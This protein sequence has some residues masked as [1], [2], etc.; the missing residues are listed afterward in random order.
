[1]ASLWTRAPGLPVLVVGDQEAEAH[2]GGRPGVRCATLEVDPY[3]RTRA[4]R[5][6][7]LAGRV[8]PLL[9]GLSPWD[10]TLYVDA[11]SAFRAD[12]A[13]GF[14][15]LERWDFALAETE[16]RTLQD[17]IAGAE[18]TLW[19]AQWTG[20]PHLLYHN[21]GMLF[22]RKH[23]RVQRLFQLWAEEWAR[24]EGWDEQVALLRALL[25]S[26]AL[27]LTLPYTWNHRFGGK[28]VLLH[29]R[30]GVGAARQ[31]GEPG[32]EAAEGEAGDPEDPDRLVRVQVGPRRYVR[33]RAH[34]AEMYRERYRKE[35]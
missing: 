25:R 18:E 17:S 2:F 12:P 15:L 5:V 9:Y 28:A 35:A 31:V 13:L 6:Q 20:T 34:E 8:K 24:F 23:E 22:W 19:T 32:A 27:Y 21:S 29:H 11:D 33:C 30:F 16:T 1:M 4:A 26:E 7:F 3:D 14:D 10:Q